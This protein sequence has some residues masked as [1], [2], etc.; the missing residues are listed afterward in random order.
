M[1]A[2]QLDNLVREAINATPDPPRP[3]PRW[4]LLEHSLLNAPALAVI[5]VGAVTLWGVSRFAVTGQLAPGQ[6]SQL[7]V[8]SV[9]V[10][11][12]GIGLIG[13]PLLT[14]LRLARILRR[15][16]RAVARVTELEPPDAPDTVAEL[17][18][19]AART[20]RRVR[21]HRLVEHSGGLFEEPFELEADWSGQLDIGSEI[22]VLVHPQ[23]PQVLLELGL[24]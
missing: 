17:D 12:L 3:V 9:V 6:E 5:A 13:L 7:T 20:R 10:G 8:F 21:G 11:G 2:A 24:R 19:E 14:Y 18:A 4:A 22:D 16:V 23:R 15:G 1:D